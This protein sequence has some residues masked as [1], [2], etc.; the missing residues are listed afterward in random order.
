MRWLPVLAAVPSGA[1]FDEV[2]VTLEQLVAERGVD[3]V[4]ITDEARALALASTPIALPPDVPE[5]LSPIVAIV[6]AQL[7]AL[8]LARVRGYDVEAPRGLTKVTRTW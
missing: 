5:W 2:L 7:F 8:H 3:L 4:A 6:P 1:V